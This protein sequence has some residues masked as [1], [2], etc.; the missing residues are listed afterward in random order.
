MIMLTLMG[1]TTYSQ[2]VS[3]EWADSLL[4]TLSTNTSDAGRMHIYFM[5]AQGQISKSGENKIDLDSA[6]AY[7]HKA[8]LLNTKIKSKDADAFQVLLESLLAKER[9]LEKKRKRTGRK[10]G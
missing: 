5:A 2:G 9:R 4:K 3:T 1:I 8:A 10:S 6:A 7:M